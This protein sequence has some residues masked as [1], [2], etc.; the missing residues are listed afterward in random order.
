MSDATR[1]DRRGKRSIRWRATLFRLVGS[2][3]AVTVPAWA[4][5]FFVDSQWFSDRLTGVFSIVVAVLTTIAALTPTVQSLERF[6]PKWV[7]WMPSEA[8]IVAAAGCA[9]ITSVLVNAGR[10]TEGFETLFGV[11]ISATAAAA[12]FGFIRVVT[13]PSPASVLGRA[14]AEAALTTRSTDDTN[15][16][17]ESDRGFRG[18]Q[19]EIGRQDVAEGFRQYGDGNETSARFFLAIGVLVFGGS[20]AAA[21]WLVDAL[22]DAAGS[23]AILSRAAI[24]IPGAAVFG[25]FVREAAARR[26]YA[27]WAGL[28]AIQ[29]ENLGAFTADMAADSRHELEM[30]FARAVFRGGDVALEQA[31]SSWRGKQPEDF[32]SVQAAE[33]MLPLNAFSDLLGVVKTAAETVLTLQRAAQAGTTS[34]ETH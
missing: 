13:P 15:R 20:V 16:V 34:K 30:Q 12:F 28:I 1:G 27:A 14:T 29:A 31:V 18:A 6:S 21:L 11:A 10:A 22:G 4:F 32:S 7:R 3:V 17:S 25:V 2:V 24:T 5:Y 26:R 9:A 19:A 33:P 8:A 23:A